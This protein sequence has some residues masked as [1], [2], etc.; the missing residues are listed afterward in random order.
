MWRGG[1]KPKLFYNPEDIDKVLEVVP[2]GT[3]RELVAAV[4]QMQSTRHLGRGGE[5]IGEGGE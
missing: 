3:D 5:G 4:L 2:A 1:K